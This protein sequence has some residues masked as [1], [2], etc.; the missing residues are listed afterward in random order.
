MHAAVLKERSVND[1]LGLHGR[2]IWK[3]DCGWLE[4]GADLISWLSA[5]YS[6][7]GAME[8]TVQWRIGKTMIMISL[9]QSKPLGNYG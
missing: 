4:T 1:G 3:S 2:L 5:D 7:N 8:N 6:S 9:I